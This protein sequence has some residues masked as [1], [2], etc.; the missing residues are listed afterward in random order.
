VLYLPDTSAAPLLP[1]LDK[2]GHLAVFAAVIVAGVRAGLP[3]RPLA[4]LL[5]VHA[6]VSELIQHHLLAERS[7]DWRD[8]VADLAGVAL[9]YLLCRVRS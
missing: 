1:G 6:V 7:G 3:A 4:A 5:I 9:G 2:I 8:V